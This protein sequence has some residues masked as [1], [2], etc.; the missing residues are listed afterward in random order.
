M[1]SNPLVIM[2]SSR[3]IS[4]FINLDGKRGIEGESFTA[5]L[6]NGLIKVF[7]AFVLYFLNLCPLRQ[8]GH[9]DTYCLPFKTIT[10]HLVQRVS[11]GGS[12]EHQRPCQTL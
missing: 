11:C 12:F 9:T 8:Q 6:G 2:A 5:P 3:A 4:S 7:A 1:M 10:S